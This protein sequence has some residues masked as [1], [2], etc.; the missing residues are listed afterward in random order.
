MVLWQYQYMKIQDSELVVPEKTSEEFF[1]KTYYY[2][3]YVELLEA[4]LLEC[5]TMLEAYYEELMELY[6]REQARNIHMR[7]LIYGE[8]NGKN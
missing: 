5:S 7:D 8:V 6:D 1:G 4:R 2:P 3:E